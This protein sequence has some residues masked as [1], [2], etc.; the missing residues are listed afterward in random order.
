MTYK[1]IRIY[2]PHLNK[3]NK[4]IGKGLSL[5]EAQDHCNSEHTR[6]EGVYFDGYVREGK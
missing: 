3:K 2:A 4:V 1:I 5:Q 6:K